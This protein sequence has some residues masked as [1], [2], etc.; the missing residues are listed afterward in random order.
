MITKEQKAQLDY[1]DL[2]IANYKTPKQRLAIE[3][4]ERDKRLKRREEIKVKTEPR[5][6]FINSRKGKFQD[7]FVLEHEITTEDIDREVELWF[8]QR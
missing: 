8:N 6:I 2:M 5:T 4:S 7:K 1:N 3:L